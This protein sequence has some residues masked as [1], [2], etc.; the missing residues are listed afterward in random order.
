MEWRFNRVLIIGVS[1]T[2]V[3]QIC[4][5]L[6]IDRELCL[7]VVSVIV[8]GVMASAFW[9]TAPNQSHMFNI[10]IADNLVVT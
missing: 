2:H 10:A 5:A 6:F 8:N 3:V 7:L 9:K 1:A 4:R